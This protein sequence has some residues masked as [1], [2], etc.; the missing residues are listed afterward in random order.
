MFWSESVINGSAIV[1]A[2]SWS[3][4]RG[5]GRGRDK[6]ERGVLGV[7]R[8]AVWEEERKGRIGRRNLLQEAEEERDGENHKSTK[9]S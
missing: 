7:E 6:E 3:D 2:D 1:V 9:E 5:G 4:S 8:D